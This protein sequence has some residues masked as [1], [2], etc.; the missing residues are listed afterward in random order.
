[1]KN[2]LKSNFLF[3]KQ[4]LY[5]DI[6]DRSFFIITV[7]L[8]FLAYYIW[9]RYLNTDDFFIYMRVNVYPV[10][11]LGVILVVNTFLAIS[12]YNREKEVGYF[13]FIGNILVSLL[14][15]ILEI[16]YLLNK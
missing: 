7:L 5:D 6:V 9:H 14:I 1:M 11:L 16:F 12:S 4:A 10:K 13:L 8:F 15:L 2:Y 3:L